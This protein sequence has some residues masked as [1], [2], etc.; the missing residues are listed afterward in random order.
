MSAIDT[1]LALNGILTAQSYFDGTNAVETQIRALAQQIYDS[2]D[3]VFMLETN[4]RQ[5]YLGWKPNEQRAGSRF[6]IADAFGTGKYS[7]TNGYPQTIDYYTDEGLILILLAAGSKTNP[8][9]GTL[10]CD[11]IRQTN[12]VGLIQSWPGALFTFQFLHAFLDTRTLRF[13]ACSCESPIDWFENSRQAM[14]Q[15]FDYAVANPKNIPTYGSNAWGLT[16]NEGPDDAYR[17]NGAPALAASPTPDEDGTVAY[18][19]M[20]SS[21][22]FGDDLRQKAISALPAAWKAGHWHP[23]FGL[24]DAFHRDVNM[25]GITNAMRNHGPWM[26]RSLFAIDVGPMALHLENA[27]TGLIWDLLSRNPN[28]QRALSRFAAPSAVAPAP[29]RGRSEPAHHGD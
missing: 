26:N 13:P 12:Q 21:V 18:Y 20:I 5:F 11:L 6:A 15:A 1:G 25:L 24:P 4:S 19:G 2:V 29:L 16:A 22:S 8:L 27:R 7:G 28:I 10:V 9:A 17:A 3:W 23:R 14:L